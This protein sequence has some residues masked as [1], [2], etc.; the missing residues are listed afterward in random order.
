ML[1]FYKPRP[2]L[3]PGDLRVDG[4]SMEVKQK[5]KDKDMIKVCELPDM[6]YRLSIRRNMYVLIY[7]S[8]KAC[9]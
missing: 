4:W 7:K 9:M 1:K 3:G 2:K 6:L 8:D 5:D